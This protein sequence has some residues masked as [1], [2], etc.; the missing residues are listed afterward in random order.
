MFACGL[1]YDVLLIKETQDLAAVSP[2]PVAELL[3]KRISWRWVAF[4]LFVLGTVATAP[5]CVLYSKAVKQGAYVGEQADRTGSPSQTSLW[6]ADVW[7]GGAT[8]VFTI[9]YLLQAVD[10]IVTLSELA[11]LRGDAPRWCDETHGVL[12]LF[13]GGLVAVTVANWV[14]ILAGSPQTW[15]LATAI[16]FA[17]PGLAALTFASFWLLRIAVREFNEEGGGREANARTPLLG[18]RS[19]A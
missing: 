17:S 15:V 5:G 4:V 11:K 2:A 14:I 9:G 10:A 8:L 19:R 7:F 18:G 6:V 1:L 16:A 13:G 12:Y 3:T